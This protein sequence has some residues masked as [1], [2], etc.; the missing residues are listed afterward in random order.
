MA[1]PNSARK[2]DTRPCPPPPECEPL[3]HLSA[4]VAVLIESNDR[5]ETRLDDMK[6]QIAKTEEVIL[7]SIAA[8]VKSQELFEILV[9]KGML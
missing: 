5:L 6:I 4:K 9:R 1:N 2:F 3:A 8:L 7:E